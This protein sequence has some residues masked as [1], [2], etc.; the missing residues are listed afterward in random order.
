MVIV[1]AK[2]ALCCMIMNSYSMTTMTLLEV[3]D[4]STSDSQTTSV[5]TTANT[6]EVDDSV[7][8]EVDNMESDEESSIYDSCEES[9]DSTLDEA[10]LSMTSTVVQ[11]PSYER[12][13][14]N[15][16]LDRTV[17]PDVIISEESG[18]VEFQNAKW[19]DAVDDD[20]ISQQ[21]N[22][23]DSNHQEFSDTSNFNDTQ[24]CSLTRITLRSNAGSSVHDIQMQDDSIANFDKDGDSVEDLA[25]MKPTRQIHH[26]IPDIVLSI[27]LCI[28]I[29]VFKS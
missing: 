21:E 12:L 24:N 17:I 15:L 29:P 28:I 11:Q 22:T 10:S 8:Q 16:A 13:L 7:H 19:E 14:D 4:K 9:F 3:E 27:P 20:N 25:P 26:E 1:L 18:D 6:K 2:N 5:D 23:N